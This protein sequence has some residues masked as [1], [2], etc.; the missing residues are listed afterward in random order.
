MKIWFE[1]SQVCPLS[2]NKNT[3]N[4]YARGIREI[5]YR[6]ATAAFNKK[7]LSPANWT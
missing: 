5:K 7:T 1:Y 2:L 6:I 3:K 4:N